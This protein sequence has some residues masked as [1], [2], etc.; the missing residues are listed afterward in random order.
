MLNRLSTICPNS[1]A[2]T[3]MP[4]PMTPIAKYG[5]HWSHSRAS[6][7]SDTSANTASTT[8]GPPITRM[9]FG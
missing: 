1:P 5:P 7:H 8:H 2:P 9:V 6:H 3:S 4:V